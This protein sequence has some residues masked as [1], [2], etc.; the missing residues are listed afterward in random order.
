[1]L[2]QL[3]HAELPLGDEVP[4][5]LAELVFPEGLMRQTHALMVATP[6][7]QLISCKSN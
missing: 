4:A 5:P 2:A 1:M 6:S 7:A 3:A